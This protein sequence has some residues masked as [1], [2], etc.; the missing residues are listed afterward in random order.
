M[1]SWFQRNTQRGADVGE[2]GVIGP[3]GGYFR[4]F[5]VGSINQSINQSIKFI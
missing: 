4:N 3:P 2:F 1:I 5:L